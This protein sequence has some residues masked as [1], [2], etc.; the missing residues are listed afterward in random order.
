[1]AGGSYFLVGTSGLCVQVALIHEILFR[2]AGLTIPSAP[3]AINN[4][5]NLD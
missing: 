4:I 5:C 3:V 2:F 1:M